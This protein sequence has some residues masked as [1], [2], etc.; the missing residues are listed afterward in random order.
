MP[1]SAPRPCTYPGCPRLVSG[2]PRCDEHRVRAWSRKHQTPVKRVTGRRLQHLRQQLFA[3]RPLCAECQRKGIVK[4]A[5][6]RDHIVPLAEG[7]TDDPSNIQGLCAECHRDK[8]LAEALR[9]R[10]RGG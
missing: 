2:G 8:T 6:Q 9:A 7:G 10:M 1:T 3:E 5:T 4:L